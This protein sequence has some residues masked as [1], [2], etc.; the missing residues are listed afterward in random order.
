MGTIAKLKQVLAAG[1]VVEL[2]PGGIIAYQD[3]PDG[4]MGAN[5]RMGSCLGDLAYQIDSAWH[6]VFGYPEDGNASQAYIDM[7]GSSRQTKDERPL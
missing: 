7:F 5:G 1:Y 2:H 4:L 6:L 3:N